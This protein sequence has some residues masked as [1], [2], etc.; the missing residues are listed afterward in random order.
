MNYIIIAPIYTCI[1]HTFGHMQIP[2]PNL[3][4]EVESHIWPACGHALPVTIN[5]LPTIVG[6]ADVGN[7]TLHYTS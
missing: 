7:D 1:A 2:T 3:N 4:M 5:R 6:N